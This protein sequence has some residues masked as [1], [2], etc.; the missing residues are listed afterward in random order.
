MKK[1]NSWR[2]ALRIARRDA[3]RAKGRSLLVIAMIALPIVGVSAAALTLRSAELST[4]EELTRTLGQADARFAY[5]GGGE[6][7]LQEPT[8]GSVYMEDGGG[9][10]AEPVS[11][12]DLFAGSGVE[13]LV[14]VQGWKQVQSRHGVLE[15][16]IRETD[17]GHP[18]TEG[19]FTLKRGEFP[20]GPREVAATDAFLKE[21]GLKVGSR[22]SLPDRDGSFRITGA[23]ELPSNLDRWQLLVQPGAVW[24]AEEDDRVSRDHLLAVDGG[25]SWEKVVEANTHGW[26]VTSRS[27]Y[28]QPPPDSEVPAYADAG[29][30]SQQDLI[31]GEV[32][33]VLG[34]VLVL[35]IMEVCLLAGPAFAVGARRS[36]RMLGL[37]GANGGDRRHIR[38]IMLSSGLVLGIAAAVV[39][40]VLG[41]LLMIAFQPWLESLAGSRFGVL[42]FRPLELTAIA[43]LGVVT[44]LLAAMVPAI[45]SARA[46]VLESLTGR[47]GIRRTGR[48][49]PM[50]G[51]AGFVLGSA[52]ALLGSLFLRNI[53]LVAG[54]AVVAQLGLVAM[55]PLLVG[56]FGRIGG[57]LPLSGRLALRDAV[58]NRS[59]TAPAVAAVL[60]AVAGTMTVA[61]YTAG[62]DTQQRA[63]YR[64]SLPHGGVSIWADEPGQTAA[65]TAVR[66]AAELEL[67][68]A[69]RA[70]VARL[71]GGDEDCGVWGWEDHCSTMHVRIPPEN[72][73]DWEAYE[74]AWAAR[75]GASPDAVGDWRCAPGAGGRHVPG[76]EVLVGGPEVLRALGIE[77]D[78]AVRALESGEAVVTSRSR[79]DD[80]GVLTLEFFGPAD[81]AE[82]LA[83]G[84]ERE[85]DR[86]VAFPAVLAEL[87]EEAR[88]YGLHVLLPPAA[89]AEAGLNTVDYGTVYRT[90]EV[91]DS[92]Q[93]Q[94]FDGAIKDLSPVPDTYIEYGH[95]ESMGLVLLVLA[96]FAGLVT[97][98][99]AGIATGLAQAD[100]ERDLATLSAVG[101]PPRVRR[102][103]SGLQ[104]A[105]IAAMGTGLGV[106]SGLI[107]GVGLR[108]VQYREDMHWWER[109][110]GHGSMPEL[111]ISVPWG[112]MLQLVVV[113]PVVAGLLAALLTRS[114]IGLARREG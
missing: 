57:L 85:P 90:S 35:V 60:A 24:G 81:R 7:I 4:Q 39:G 36:R 44:G 68:T 101:A 103:L 78:N 75:D 29:M 86:E 52:T 12:A 114:R 73:C 27:V 102:T 15:A 10:E 16:E 87:D 34:A 11:P 88:D 1:W 92:A 61:T 14:D 62:A 71:L 48:T 30:G 19:L 93:R 43:L 70:D 80:D 51:A 32:A 58:R 59:R 42:D 100:S 18:L 83:D 113:V 22:L 53:Y 20:A 72:E 40:T 28:E 50:W 112:T 46:P 77:D 65:L 111:F 8:G 95:R 21:S 94:A 106:L 66:Q 25:V 69:E 9:P 104:C 26:F 5:W 108:L 98:G 67:A 37:V 109:S 107:P 49:L 82:E 2:A 96:L 13:L 45:T 76:A 23:Y 89:V 33:A 3:L 47:R 105:V 74:E 97:L 64:A 110:G 55:T 41:I 79:V 31:D 54:G 99:A 56:V 6:P 17:T 63:E 38:A 84:R 91:P